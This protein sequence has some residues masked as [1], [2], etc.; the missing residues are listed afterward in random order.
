MSNLI[1][2][3]L[4]GITYATE[5]RIGGDEHRSAILADMRMTIDALG[6]T[7]ARH[8]EARANIDKL[9]DMLKPGPDTD[10]LRAQMAEDLDKLDALATFNTYILARVR[11]GAFK[12]MAELFDK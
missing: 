1:Q 12:R 4:G 8:K 3:E 5:Q 2:N 11:G 7:C 6:E 10:A 9:L